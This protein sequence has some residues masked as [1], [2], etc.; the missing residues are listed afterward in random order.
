MVYNNH[1]GPL[2]VDGEE[3][4]VQYW[5]TAGSEEHARLRPLSYPQT[6]VF[7]LCLSVVDD[8]QYFAECGCW[9]KDQVH[10]MAFAQE[11]QAICPGCP[12]VMCG[13]QTDLRYAQNCWSA[14]EM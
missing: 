2:N 6:D 9:T 12:V 10:T 14:Y 7:L 11:V 4:Q 5:D 1:V 8:Q 3:H 13:T